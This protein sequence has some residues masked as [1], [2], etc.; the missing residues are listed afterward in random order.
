[1]VDPGLVSKIIPDPDS[2][3]ALPLD[4]TIKLNIGQ[5]NMGFWK[6]KRII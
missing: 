3:A 4:L 5:V 6:K 2:D 1:M